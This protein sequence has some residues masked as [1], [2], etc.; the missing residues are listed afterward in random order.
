MQLNAFV[1]D[2]VDLFILVHPS[3]NL[4]VVVPDCHDLVL[5]YSY[6]GI[7]VVRFRIVVGFLHDEN[8]GHIL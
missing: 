6:E 5:H 7:A 4:L 1:N 3:G 2:G 8:L